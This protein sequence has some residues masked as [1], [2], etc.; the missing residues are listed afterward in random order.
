MNTSTGMQVSG[1]AY[2][3]NASRRPRRDWCMTHPAAVV[4]RVKALHSEAE[5]VR[6]HESNGAL[7]EE[8]V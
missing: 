5:S 8:W 3:T 7:Y 1:T 2:L 6:P 4:L